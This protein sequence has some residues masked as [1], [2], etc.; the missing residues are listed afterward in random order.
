MSVDPSNKNDFL[1]ALL[2]IPRILNIKVSRDSRYVA[3]TWK[4]VH[5][6]LDVFLVPTDGSTRP[7]ALT[8]TPEATFVESFAPH[9]KAVIVGEDKNGNERVRL[10]E[11]KIDRP[12]EMIPLTEKDP[13][14]SPISSAIF[15]S[16]TSFLH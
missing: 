1:E 14:F 10:F 2:T 7:V 12:K 15:A 13:T 5:S 9:S 3:H 11:V 16:L 8:E 6:N 4:N